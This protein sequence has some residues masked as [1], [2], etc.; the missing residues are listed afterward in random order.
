MIVYLHLS[1][2]QGVFD[3]LF[4][5]K[6]CRCFNT[7]T[8][9]AEGAADLLEALSQSTQLE[10][11][12]LP[13]CNQI[14]TGAWQKVRNAKWFNLK[15]AN[16]AECL[17]ERNGWRFSCCLRCLF[18]SAGSCPSS[19]LYRL[20]SCRV[21]WS[22]LGWVIVY[23]HIAVS[24]CVRQV[25]SDKTLQVLQL[26][27]ERSRWRRR[28]AWSL[29][30]VATAGRVE[31]LWLFSDPSIGLAKTAWCQVA[32]F[33]EGRFL[34]VPRREKW[35][36]GFLVFYVYLFVSVGNCSSSV[37]ICEVVR[38]AQVD[39]D[40]FKMDWVPALVVVSTCFR[41][42]VSDKTL[43]VLRRWHPRSRWN[44][45]FASGLESF[46]GAGSVEFWGLLLHPRSSLATT[47]GW[48]L[49]EAAVGTWHPRQGAA[50]SSWPWG[51]GR[52]ERRGSIQTWSEWRERRGGS[53]MIRKIITAVIRLFDATWTR[54]PL[55]VQVDIDISPT[56]LAYILAAWGQVGPPK[57]L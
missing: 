52:R 28:F 55:L 18:V 5:T 45:R 25:H 29:E 22:W 36:R 1:L 43:Q 19:D 49:A 32:E 57:K 46:A 21:S 53:A 2:S 11:L 17:A 30:P 9:G 12:D 54:F 26:L 37:W 10:N 50:A 14:P 48:R 3:R 56:P 51:T 39:L 16:F 35:L 13:F 40:G 41:Q 15:K 47:S 33:E 20:V 38:W 31:F 4:L 44:R 6:H 27:H 34:S 8:K 24:T 42:I 23:L 7:A